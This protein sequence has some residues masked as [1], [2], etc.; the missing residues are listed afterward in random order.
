ML[1]QAVTAQVGAVMAVTLDSNGF[2]YTQSMILTH[3]AV[4]Y[5]TDT[6]GKALL[7][8]TVCVYVSYTL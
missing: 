1:Q 3:V 7:S 6:T 2:I 8:W 4:K 5:Q